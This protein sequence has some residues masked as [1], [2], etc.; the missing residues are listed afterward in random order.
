MG[1]TVMWKDDPSWPLNA[2]FLARLAN[3]NPATRIV[4]WASKTTV[5]ISG[6]NGLP[7]QVGDKL[8]WLDTDITLSTATDLDT[9][10]VA[11]GKDY[12][13]Y[14]CDDES[15]T[16]VGLIS[17]NSTYPSG[18]D[19]D[20]SRKLGGFHTLCANVGT[21]SGHTLTGY[22][23]SEILPQSVWDLTHRARNVNMDNSGLV[24]DP[25]TGLWVAI[26]L[27]ADDGSSGFKSEYGATIWDS[28]QG[29][30]TWYDCVNRAA[31]IGGRLLTYHEFMSLAAGSNEETNITGSA[32]PGTT[33]GHADTA[34]R[35]M[36]SNIGCEDCCGVMLQWGLD[37]S[38]RLD[39]VPTGGDPAW[40]YSD[41]PNGKGSVYRQ[42]TYGVVMPLLGGRWNV[43]SH[44]GSAC[45]YLTNSPWLSHAS[46]GARVACDKL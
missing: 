32:D 46:F 20:T 36:I 23:A 44:C 42:G 27:A 26:Y 12:Y 2:A 16:P 40:A 15:D 43:G 18:Y 33:G 35:R 13:V 21:I 24:Y 19:A 30:A 17:L 5:K 25:G 14:L 4:E 28:G 37:M 45:V 39:P 11:A 41:L 7:I 38:Y 29:A 1:N 31:K 22:L 6:S 34:S 3:V 10:S 9:G 8:F